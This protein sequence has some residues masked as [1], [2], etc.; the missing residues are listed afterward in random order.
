V[1][2]DLIFI[3]PNDVAQNLRLTIL[4]HGGSR[5]LSL[6]AR[7]NPF[8]QTRVPPPAPSCAKDSV[9]HLPLR[10]SAPSSPPTLLPLRRLALDARDRRLNK[11]LHLQHVDLIAN[12]GIRL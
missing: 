3:D 8:N 12:S 6:D 5:H 10:A 4:A 2:T 11:T 1:I 7:N 9:R